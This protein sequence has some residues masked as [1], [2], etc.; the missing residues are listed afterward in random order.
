MTKLKFKIFFLTLLLAIFLPVL[1][2]ATDFVILYVNVSGIVLDNETEEPINNA[3]INFYSAT[4]DYYP[5]ASCNTDKNGKY[6]IDL[7]YPPPL[8]DIEVQAVNYEKTRK[9]DI[10]I[11]KFIPNN[12]DFSL[13]KKKTPVII[14]HGITGS[15]YKQKKGWVLDPI[16]HTYDNLY[17]ALIWEGYTPDKDLFNFSYDWGKINIATAEY[18]KNKIDE[19]KI[20][21]NVDKV[22]LITHSMG[23]LVARQYIESNYKNDIDK[24]IFL[25]TPHNGANRAYLM[26]EGTTGFQEKEG[27]ILKL[28]FLLKAH[29]CDLD[30]YDY[31]HM[32]VTS[33]S[34]LLPTYDY[35]RDADT[36]QLRDYP[37]NYPTNSFLENL[38]SQ[39]NLDILINSGIEISNIVSDSDISTLDTLVVEN[40]D[41][42]KKWEHGEPTSYEYS[43]GDGTVLIK[44]AKGFMGDYSIVVNSDHSDLPT[45]AINQVLA[46]LNPYIIEF[47]TEHS[48]D[49]V[50]VDD[51]LVITVH[52]PI[53]I[54]VT[55]P[56]GSQ[57]G[58]QSDPNNQI[59]L[60]FYSGT[61]D[62]EFITIP[63]PLKGNYKIEAFGTGSGEYEIEVNYINDTQ[64]EL[65][66]TISGNAKNGENYDHSFD[67][68][69]GYNQIKI[70]ILDFKGKNFGM[71]FDLENGLTG[72]YTAGTLDF[73]L[74]DYDLET[75]ELEDTT[76]INIKQEGSLDFVYDINTEVSGDEDFCNSLYLKATLDGIDYA[77]VKLKDFTT[78]GIT[79]PQSGDDWQFVI[80]D[81]DGGHSGQAC[82]FKIIFNAWQEKFGKEKGFTDQEI[83]FGTVHAEEEPDPDCSSQNIKLNEFLPNPICSDSAEKPNGEWVE[84][85]NI[86]DCDIDLA[87]YYITD[88]KADKNSHRIEIEPCR[89]DTGG[90]VILAKGFLVVYRKGNENCNSHGFSLNNKGDTVNLFDS[91]NKLID[92]YKYSESEENKSYSRIPDGAGEWYD[93]GIPTPGAPNKLYE[94]EEEDNNGSDTGETVIKTLFQRG[95]GQNKLEDDNPPAGGKKNDEED[96]DTNEEKDGEKKDDT[97]EKEDEDPLRQPTDGG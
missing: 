58:N 40:S 63:N 44:S 54:L 22:N 69:G 60:A 24:L 72:G 33:I 14:I 56:N 66:Q 48:I 20:I 88:E 38:N 45:K 27:F 32:H 52:S 39:E 43:A 65:I 34:E 30:L 94:E 78:L 86:S 70:A 91:E 53:N 42:D 83:A 55:A 81:P 73:S 62:P 59:P 28:F 17:S 4:S 13:K 1:S 8:M 84:L 97:D 35:L 47:P 11:L 50:T 76:E 74:S 49:W 64:Q 18:L 9:T 6:S 68:E 19:V 93:Y 87:G 36:G 5:P 80:S 95:D 85:Y 15:W 77:S 90:T 7:I 82:D 25:G 46:I 41:D 29:A 12:I 26:W 61:E 79:F 10:E 16:M 96:D 92:F 31:I 3:I 23:G 2:L 71:F 21:T 89:T 51:I 67:F 57:I 37:D 75:V